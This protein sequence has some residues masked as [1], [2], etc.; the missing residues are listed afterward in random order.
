VNTPLPP[1]DRFASIDIG[2]N[3]ILLLIAETVQGKLNPLFE[4]ETVVRLGE[5]LKKNGVVL[6]AAMQRGYE[7]LKQY[8]G[9][10]RAWDVRNIFA[11]GTSVLRD[12]RNSG[13]FCRRVQ[14]GLHLNVDVISGEEEASLSYLAVVRDVRET[15]KPILVVDVGGG[16]TEFIL[17]E[18][19]RV[20]EWVSLPLGLVGFT[21]QFLISDPVR[22]GEWDRMADVIR[23]SLSEIPHPS[24][25]FSMISVGGTGTTLVSVQLRLKEVVY[26]RIHHVI[27]SKEAIQNQ[28]S[29][30]RSKTLEGRKSIP[31]LP[32]DRAD[33]ILAGGTILYLAMEEL[34]C[35]SVMIN[36]HGVRYGLLYKRLTGKSAFLPASR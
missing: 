14:E 21:E 5:G 4:M 12:A 29:L 26:E 34:R 6:P 35:P 2:T 20:L 18:G 11:V 10:C 32:W 33:V 27:L 36:T 8:L 15:V 9:Y 28:L 23:A 3:T 17:G 22:E 31:G 19:E 30:Y 25:P 13:E 16:S 7:T 24:E 1:L